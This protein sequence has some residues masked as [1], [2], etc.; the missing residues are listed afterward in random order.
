MLQHVTGARGYGGTVRI[1]SGGIRALTHAAAAAAAAAVLVTNIL[2]W[3]SVSGSGAAKCASTAADATGLLLLLDAEEKGVE[4]EE[5][6]AL[7]L[8]NNSCDN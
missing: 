1:G 8:P 7:S 4:V 6:G 5:E 3:T 2:L